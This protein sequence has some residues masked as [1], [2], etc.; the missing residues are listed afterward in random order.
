MNVYFSDVD[1]DADDDIC[2]SHVYLSILGVCACVCFVVSCIVQCVLT[3][4][5]MCC[6]NGNEHTVD[7]MSNMNKMC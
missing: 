7:L 2:V 6:N 1:D 3:A 4:D 5:R